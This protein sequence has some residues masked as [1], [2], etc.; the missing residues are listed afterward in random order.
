[1]HLSPVDAAAAKRLRLEVVMQFMRMQDRG[2]GIVLA[3]SKDVLKHLE[4]DGEPV[5]DL[6]TVQAYVS[7][8][9]A[10][11]RLVTLPY[12]PDLDLPRLG[13]RWRRVIKLTPRRS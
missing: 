4:R 7:T 11:G 5:H 12:S 10:E 1:M 9:E 2:D 13:K 8:L 6:R 3:T